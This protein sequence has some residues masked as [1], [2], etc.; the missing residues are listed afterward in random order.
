M[1][2][3]RLLKNIYFRKSLTL[4]FFSKSRCIVFMGLCFF[5]VHLSASPLTNLTFNLL[6]ESQFYK[7][8]LRLYELQKYDSAIIF[9]T[10]A[11]EINQSNSIYFGYRGASERKLKKYD[12]ALSDFNKAIESNDKIS[13]LYY[14]RGKVKEILEKFELA[15][16]DYDIS[17][18]LDA[19]NYNAIYSRVYVYRRLK[20]Y[21]AGLKDINFLIKQ[22][23]NKYYGNYYERGQIYFEMEEYALA[24]IDFNVFINSERKDAFYDAFYARGVS[25]TMLNKSDSAITDLKKAIEIKPSSSFAYR[26]IGLAYAQK[27]DSVK[28]RTYFD[29][30]IEL[31]SKDVS[32]TYYYYG[33]AEYLFGNCQKALGLIKKGEEKATPNQTYYSNYY[34]VRGLVKGCVKDTTG[35]LDDFE[36]AIKMDAKDYEAYFNRIKLL[37][38]DAKHLKQTREY[39]E[40]VI[41]IYPNKK[42]LPFLYTMDALYSMYL[43]DTIQAEKSY[44]KAIKM[45]PEKGYVYYNLAAYYF[46]FR[47]RV[48]YNTIIIES[49]QKSI[50]IQK[51]KSD[52]Y[53]LLGMAYA[54]IDNDNIKACE[55]LNTAN[56]ECKES[57]G[58]KKLE[59]LFC[60]GK[61][62]PKEI[63]TN[64][65]IIP[66]E[67][68]SLEG[69]FYHP[70]PSEELVNRII[71]LIH[72]Q[73]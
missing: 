11:I 45:A 63:G 64:F 40:Q 54:I 9:F 46:Y 36:T 27:L 61:G 50:N 6:D 42:D 23:P 41:D 33:K 29:K 35:A 62:R 25:Y 34:N 1:K 5:S 59:T 71:S 51:D 21:E 67:A 8:G 52:Y 65:L 28:S 48:E 30:S 60:K 44:K 26:Y 56:K 18:K 66:D 58:I 68:T 2:M 10:K 15:E 19:K 72:E 12:L 22:F 31:D 47:N 53:I 4:L 39:I 37:H 43:A 16:A 7:E 13:W 24:I 70:P 69:Y 3:N 49:L 38:A 73:F 57:K 17:I 55:T 32:A 14:E 20:K